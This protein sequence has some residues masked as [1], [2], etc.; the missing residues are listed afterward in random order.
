MKIFLVGCGNLGKR[1]AEGIAKINNIEE[2]HCYDISKDAAIEALSIFNK[3]REKNKLSIP[4]TVLHESINYILPKYDFCIISS[5][6]FKRAKL[7]KELKGKSDINYWIIEKV[8]EQSVEEIINIEK[9]NLNYAWVNTFRSSTKL[10]K[11]L[12]NILKRSNYTHSIIKG[13]NINI[14][15]NLIHYIDAYEFILNKNISSIEIDESVY[16]KKSKR[17]GFIEIFGK[18]SLNFE[19]KFSL[20]IIQ[21]AKSISFPKTK[22]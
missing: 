16:S 2:F 12:K 8:L 22:I 5:T 3:V 20:E 15:S 18:I 9:L 17:V 6:A 10:W 1:Y 19:N 11:D 7:I 21:L 14:G 4:L 13:S